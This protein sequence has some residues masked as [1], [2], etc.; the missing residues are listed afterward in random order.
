MRN[1]TGVIILLSLA[2]GATLL[3]ENWPHWRGPTHDGVKPA[4]RCPG[5]PNAHRPD[6]QQTTAPAGRRPPPTR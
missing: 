3:A 6:R 1:V 4:C 2:S 5:V